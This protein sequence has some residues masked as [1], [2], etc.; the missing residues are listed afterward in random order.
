MTA[1][2]MITAPGRGRER[3]GGYKSNDESF[4]I[5]LSDK[6]DKYDTELLNDGWTGLLK[7]E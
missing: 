3:G 7:E 4:L 6:M 5:T 1:R 2:M